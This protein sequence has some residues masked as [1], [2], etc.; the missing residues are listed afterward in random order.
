M[1]TP[2]HQASPATAD[3]KPTLS[4]GQRVGNYSILRCLDAAQGRWIACEISSLEEVQLHARTVTAATE[5]RRATWEKLQQLPEGPFVRVIDAFEQDGVRYELTALPTG[6]SLHEWM[7]CH[8]LSLPALESLVQQIGSTLHSLHEAGLVL[9]R[10]RPDAV[11]I[12]EDESTDMRV[13][14]CD[15]SEAA[16][17]TPP[18]LVPVAVNPYYAPPEAAGLSEHTAADTLC[19]WDWWELGRLLQEIVHGRHIYGLIFER[20]VAERPANLEP[21]A[22]ALLLERDQTSVRAGAVELLPETVGPRTRRLLRGLLAS[23]RDGRWR[24]L[25]L[26]FWLRNEPPLDRYDLP[27]HARLFFWRGQAMTLAEASDH[28]SR[29]ENFADGVEQLFPDPANRAALAHFLAD[30]PQYRDDHARLAQLL[31]WIDMTPWQDCPLEIRREIVAGLVWLI[32][33]ADTPQRRLTVLG[34]RI[35]P[36][37][38]KALFA[39]LPAETAVALVRAL[40][41]SPCLQLLKPLDATAARALESL[42]GSGFEAVALAHARS[43]IAASD[44]EAEAG[45]L[46]TSLDADKTL[47]AAAQAVINTYATCRD[48]SLAALLAC[49]AP[50]RAEQIILVFT[51]DCAAHYGY[52]TKL[53]WH[54]QRHRELKRRIDSLAAA[55]FWRRLGPLLCGSPA[56]CGAWPVAALIWLLPA[57]LAVAAGQWWWTVLLI[58]AGGLGRL[59]AAAEIRRSLHRHL[60]QAPPWTGRDGARRCQREAAALLGEEASRS[61]AELSGEFDRLAAEIIDV[62]LDPRPPRPEALA[63]FRALWF[64]SLSATCLPF[65]GCLA[66]ITGVQSLAPDKNTP[67]DPTSPASAQTKL[68]KTVSTDGRTELYEIENDGFGGKRRGP[69]R[70][71]PLPSNG[72]HRSFAVTSQRPTTP[73][74]AAQ[75]LVSAELLLDP[76]PRQ[77]LDLLLAVPVSDGDPN[78]IGIVIYEPKSRQMGDPNTYYL[79]QPPADAAW[80][81]L[82]GHPR[83]AYLGLPPGGPERVRVSFPA[84][85]D[86]I[87]AAARGEPARLLLESGK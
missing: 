12:C 21:R 84:H 63:R 43:W 80:Y 53:E 71:W 67:L 64:A 20:D 42:T 22:E 19:S 49:K 2:V 48:E 75:A 17:F 62:P 59:W 87:P 5:R 45:L 7:S 73:A 11:Y 27:R 34:W 77:G 14:L 44:F 85:A 74:E 4:I 38:L 46:R 16:L 86:S 76:Y 31:A 10:L 30:T 25:Q 41:A 69:L 72:V 18:G 28:F 13:V 68:V 56:L 29:R 66:V 61:I 8:L 35:D 50:G 1:I 60:P 55:L 65:L 33:A 24:W 58:S 15:L 52:V 82:A 23:S 54:Q 81:N 79:A 40:C 39:E 32:F 6:S 3:G 78:R 9:L 57:T 37:G 51:R 26:Q 47:Q 83:I 36:A 70:A